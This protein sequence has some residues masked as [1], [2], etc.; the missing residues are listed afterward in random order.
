MKR[1]VKIAITG[2]GIALVALILAFGLVETWPPVLIWIMP[3]TSMEP[4]I[5]AG[6]AYT[7][8]RIAPF[9]EVEVG[10]VAVY[11]RGHTRIAH[12]VVDRSDVSLITKGLNP[13]WSPTEYVSSD[14]YVGTVGDV[15]EIQALNV[16]FDHISLDVLRP[17]PQ[18][19]IEPFSSNPYRDVF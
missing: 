17:D 14:R 8:D 13:H 4:R 3:T 1:P 11:W 16:L 7:I 12:E 2:C 15:Y 5:E 10:D 6:D 18:L 19:K 9:S